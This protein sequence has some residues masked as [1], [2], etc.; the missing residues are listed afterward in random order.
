MQI[1]ETIRGIIGSRPYNV[2]TIGRSQAQVIQFD[3]MV[4]KIGPVTEESRDALKMM[5]WLRGKLPV[6]EILGF[7]TVGDTGYLLMTKVPGK[8]S[9]DREYME[10]PRH[11]VRLL[12]EGLG[13][14]WDVEI[15]GCPC[16]QSIARKLD[17]AERFVAAGECDT[18][19]V[20]PGTY[21]PGGFA[22][23]EALLQWLKDNRP[24]ERAVLSHG[25]FCLP[26]IFLQGDSVSGF[27]DLD[28]CGAGDPYGDIAICWRSL[29]HNFGGKYSRG[30]Y[31]RIDPDLLFSELG[32]SP[33]WERIRYY[34]LLDELF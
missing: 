19:N 16:D 15:S 33:D 7:E 28:H 10:N 30:V 32:I 17:Q 8:M 31:G 3:D 26:N 22:S 14:L 27:I 9:C 1:P 25:D 6:P 21:G 18:E 2:N 11:L 4:L 24:E 23:P 34:I 5:T 12:A 29:Q 13:M 20:E